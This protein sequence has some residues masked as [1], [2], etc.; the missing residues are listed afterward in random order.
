[1]MEA[2][3]INDHGCRQSAEKNVLFARCLGGE[4]NAVCMYRGDQNEM[5][6]ASKA[7]PWKLTKMP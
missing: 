2:N 5:E 7:I 4:W 3:T 6:H 1:M